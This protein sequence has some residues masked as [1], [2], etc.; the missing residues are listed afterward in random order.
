MSSTCQWDIW[1]HDC[2]CEF[3][4]LF[5]SSDAFLLQNIIHNKHTASRSIKMPVES[6]QRNIC[7]H[8]LTCRHLRCICLFHRHVCAF[9]IASHGQ[10][11]LL[12]LA[13][14]LSLQNVAL[15]NECHLGIKGFLLLHKKTNLLLVLRNFY[16]PQSSKVFSQAVF[17]GSPHVTAKNMQC[18]SCRHIFAAQHTLFFLVL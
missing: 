18:V 9:C 16:Y 3:G 1:Y 6:L 7:S 12:L 14:C 13:E 15:E 10:P 11:H 5:A 8:L 4:M 2:V 17:Y